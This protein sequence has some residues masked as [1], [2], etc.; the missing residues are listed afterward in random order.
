MSEIIVN[1]QKF[2]IKGDQPT[3]KEQLAIDTFLS[4]QKQKRT[5]ISIQKMN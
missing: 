3:P 2:R 1:G 5:L 4:G